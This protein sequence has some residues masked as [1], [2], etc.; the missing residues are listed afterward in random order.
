M[1]SFVLF[2]P[3]TNGVVEKLVSL[4]D[5]QVVSVRMQRKWHGRQLSD[6]IT[7]LQL[8]FMSLTELPFDLFRLCNAKLKFLCLNYNALCSLP[9]E[10]ALLA[11]L[12]QIW[13]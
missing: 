3:T 2:C 11:N 9:R 5:D 13:V 8:E 1:T 4:D 12:E 6:W 7:R 10:I